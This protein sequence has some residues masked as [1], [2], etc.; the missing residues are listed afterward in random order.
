MKKTVLLLFAAL[1]SCLMIFTSC[2]FL[3][4]FPFL[5]E[6]SSG[7]NDNIGNNIVMGGKLDIDMYYKN[8]GTTDYK[9][10]QNA[11]HLFDDNAMWEP[12]KVFMF[13][14]KIA[15]VGDLALKYDLGFTLNSNYDVEDVIEV[16]QFDINAKINPNQLSADSDNYIGTFKDDLT[17]SGTLLPGEFIEGCMVFRMK[18]EAG[19]EYMNTSPNDIGAIL[20]ATQIDEEDD[21]FGP[22]YDAD[23]GFD[24]DAD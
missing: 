7:D 13:D 23:I 19:S 3:S 6:M 21:V 16:Y 5:E 8:H 24:F 11:G 2:D 12:G 9:D 17:R 22:D 10:I 4:E 14:F 18:N 20:K 15:N 1:L